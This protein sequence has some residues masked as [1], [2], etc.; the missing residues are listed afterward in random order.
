MAVRLSLDMGFHLDPQALMSSH[1]I[2]IEEAELRRQI[3][4]ALYCNDKLS[5]TYTGRVCTILVSRNSTY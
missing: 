3:Y 5:V 2:D 1:G 4:W